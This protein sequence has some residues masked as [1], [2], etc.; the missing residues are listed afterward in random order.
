MESIL[1]EKIIN[2]KTLQIMQ[3]I[4][5]YTPI[6]KRVKENYTLERHSKNYRLVIEILFKGKILRDGQDSKLKKAKSQNE[7]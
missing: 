1:T 6:F 5:K 3:H 4:S 2:E 7:R